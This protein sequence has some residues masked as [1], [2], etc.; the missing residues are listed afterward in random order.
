MNRAKPANLFPAR[1]EDVFHVCRQMRPDEIAQLR[2]FY[3]CDADDGTF[4]ADA[5]AVMLLSKPQP[6]YVV[7]QDDGK[8][9]VCFG[10][11]MVSEGVW[12][13]WMAGT[14]EGWERNWR[15]ITK[16]C[17][18]VLHGLFATGARRM[19]MSAIASRTGACQ[20]YERGLLMKR[21]GLLRH[22]GRNGEDIVVFGVVAED[23]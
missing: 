17:R 5:V 1:T 18:W 4:D 13:P 15:S 21:E 20:W 8:P 11:E 9:A 14:A 23:L 16:C 7:V 3:A 10:L 19:Q 12:Q 2:A 6:R 22:F